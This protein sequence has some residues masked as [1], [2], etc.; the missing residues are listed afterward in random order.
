M[1]EPRIAPPVSLAPIKIDEASQLIGRII[2]GKYEVQSILGEGGMG[3]VYKVRH[4]ILQHRNIF[5]LKILHPRLCAEADFQSRFLREVEIAMELTHEN[6][7]Q[8]RD[9]GLTEQNLLFYTMDFFSG[10]SLKEVLA[11]EGTLSPERVVRI[12]RQILAALSDAHGSG[13]IHRDLKPENLL[14]QAIDDATDDV[15]ILDF[16]IAKMLV[17][18]PQGEDQNLTQ[19]GAIGTP[20]YM[21]PEQA[22]GESVD[23]RAD[24]Y[25]LGCIF[26]E[27]L[28]GAPPFDGKT[29][30]T[31][32][33]AHL[34]ASPPS[35]AERRPGL[36]VPDHLE[37]LVF[38]LLAK[39]RAERP[40]SAA[41][42][43]ALLDGR[44]P[45]PVVAT[46]QQPESLPR[47]TPWML[48]AAAASLAICASTGFFMVPW[49]GARQAEA[50][51]ERSSTTDEPAASSS[52]PSS[53]ASKF[54]CHVCGTVYTRGQKVGDMCHGEPL[55]EQR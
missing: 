36:M 31:I 23:H 32:L 41:S 14:I 20:R 10:S 43:I 24:L 11:R 42:V 18:G 7:V 39:D 13:I 38:Q 47:K 29:A 30:R 34:T 40:A 22:S 51:G 6:I 49:Q 9:F 46:A 28:C 48:W 44:A 12:A 26:Y 1:D 4:L 27:M 50:W 54:R 8:I 25:S 55:I 15:R 17:D 3:I 33:M 2:N 37:R 19:G 35:L 16:G 53:P 52:S 21:S 45:E 5:A